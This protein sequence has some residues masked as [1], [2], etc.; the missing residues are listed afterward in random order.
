MKKDCHNSQVEQREARLGSRKIK[1]VGR[2]LTLVTR[3]KFPT[4][5]PELEILLGRVKAQ[6]SNLISSGA[7]Y[8]AVLGVGLENERGRRG[9]VAEQAFLTAEGGNA[10]LEKKIQQELSHETPVNIKGT[11]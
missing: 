7:R 8:K 1:K 11:I 2:E 5:N 4:S 6:S 3:K 10:P 9:S